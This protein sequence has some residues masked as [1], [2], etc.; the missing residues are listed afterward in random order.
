M[1]C[2]EPF[3]A[4]DAFTRRVLQ[5]FYVNEIRDRRNLTTLW[6]TH[7]VDEA[8]IVA[9]DIYLLADG[10]LSRIDLSPYNVSQD[11]ES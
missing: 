6:I 8:L 1:L 7:D 4:L 11:M 9:D 5:G 10:A 2:D 3:S